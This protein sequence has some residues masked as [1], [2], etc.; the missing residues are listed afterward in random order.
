VKA[1]EA[2]GPLEIAAHVVH[3]ER[4]RVRRQERI[5]RRKL[6]RA[7]EHGALRLDLLDDRLDDEL[8]ARERLVE[9][10]GHHHRLSRPLPSRVEALLRGA[11]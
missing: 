4:R 1:R 11:P 9:V 7:C 2:P 3:R 5:G 6:L 8:G 10:R